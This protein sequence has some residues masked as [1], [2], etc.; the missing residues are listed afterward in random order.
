MEKDVFTVI[1]I[2]KLSMVKRDIYGSQVVKGWSVVALV[3][4]SLS[5]FELFLRVTLPV[6]LATTEI[7][8]RLGRQKRE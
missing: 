3:Y 8:M 1:F 7:G 5:R 2:W 4:V 6:S